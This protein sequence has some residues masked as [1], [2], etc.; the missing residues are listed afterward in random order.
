MTLESRRASRLEDPGADLLNQF[1]ALWDRY[2]RIALGILGGVA[3]AGVLGWFA[4]RTR[5]A[6]DAQAA[7]KLAGAQA[8]FWQGQYA[9][10]L[11][12]AKEVTTQYGS[13]P[14]GLDAHRLIGDNAYWTG[15]MKTAIAEY[16]TYL[17]KAKPGVLAESARR[18]LAYALETNGQY[19]EAAKVYE[20]L[21]GKF[22]R[23]SSAEFLTAT[24]RCQLA[25]HQPQQAAQSLQRL[26]NEFG[27][28]SYGNGARMRLAEI[29]ASVAH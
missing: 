9:R 11:E 16:R 29:Q 14:N 10:S 2:G 1:Q 5:D 13:T 25:L 20:Q 19:A 23:E 6:N 26:L 18:S 28:T 7:G 8:L 24:A 4:I 17:A 27:E 3:V 12:V 15:D 22:D 21:V